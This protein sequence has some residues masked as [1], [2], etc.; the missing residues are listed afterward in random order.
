M[1][2]ASGRNDAELWRN[3]KFPEVALFADGRAEDHLKGPLDKGLVATATDFWSAS[4]REV[5]TLV[6]RLHS[7]LLAEDLRRVET[8]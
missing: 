4:R 1:G 3:T 8:R 6:E 2:N 7:I 5:G